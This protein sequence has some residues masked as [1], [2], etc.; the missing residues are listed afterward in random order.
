[1]KKSNYSH[2]K[3]IKYE[4]PYELID[5]SKQIKNDIE[6]RRIQYNDID[7][8]NIKKQA[9]FIRYIEKIIRYSYE[10]RLWVKV[11]LKDSVCIITK[12]SKEDNQDIELHHHP[13][14]L[15]EIVEKVLGLV[16]NGILDKNIDQQVFN[17]ELYKKNYI[18]TF[19][20]QWKVI[21]LHLL[22][23]VPFVPMVSTYHKLYHKDHFDIKTED[24]YN[25]QLIPYFE[26]FLNGELTLEELVRKKMFL[27]E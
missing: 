20:I 3:R 18:S 21:E 4:S 16:E 7:F 10:Y 8:G 19:E 22:N 5:Y 25:N 6:Y 1:M 2:R 14:T 24:I 17:S 13:F 12:L 11:H 9:I 23:L 26:Q 27:N 15:F